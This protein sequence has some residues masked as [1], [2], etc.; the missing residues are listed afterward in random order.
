MTAF[1]WYFLYDAS[2]RFRVYSGNGQHVLDNIAS[3][4]LL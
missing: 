4:K 1:G 2:Q 3:D